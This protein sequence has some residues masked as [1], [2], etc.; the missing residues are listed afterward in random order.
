MN[1]A[2]S[3]ECLDCMYRS[4]TFIFTDTITYL[5][6]AG[7]CHFPPGWQQNPAPATPAFFRLA[8]K[9]EICLPANFAARIPCSDPDNQNP[10]LHDGLDFH[11]LRL[12][13]F[14]NLTSL[15]IWIASRDAP[16]FSN[17]DLPPAPRASILADLEAESLKAALQNLSSVQSVEISAALHQDINT[18][19]GEEDGFVHQIDAPNVQIWKRGTGDYYHPCIGPVN[20]GGPNDGILI[21]SKTRYVLTPEP[22]ATVVLNCSRT[23]TADTNRSSDTFASTYKLDQ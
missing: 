6:L 12:D 15:K 16:Y 14:K 13:R 4:T 20:Q 18:A 22:S 1:L 2:S 3:S 7:F 23:S 17:P 21:G 9:V 19:T 10:P 8:R 11:W 5:L